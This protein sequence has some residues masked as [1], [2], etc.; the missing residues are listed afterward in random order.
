MLIEFFGDTY[1][2]KCEHGM[3][4]CDNCKLNK[5]QVK[6]DFKNEAN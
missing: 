4:V 1:N 3:L 2:Q 5:S 6:E